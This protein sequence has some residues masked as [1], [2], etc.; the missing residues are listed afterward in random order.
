MPDVQYL[1]IPRGVP[2]I[3]PDTDESVKKADGEPWVYEFKIYVNRMLNDDAFR[4]DHDALESARAWQRIGRRAADSVVPV[5]GDDLKRMR[6]ARK[7]N[8]KLFGD[9]PTGIVLQ[10]DELGACLDSVKDKAE[11]F[12][13]LPALAVVPDVP[14]APA[15]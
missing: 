11:D 5:A 13:A 10:I 1:K 9:L 12:D 2:I 6:D 14:A 4:G 8:T 15:A 3:D 7:K